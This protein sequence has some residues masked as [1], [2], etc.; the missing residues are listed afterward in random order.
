MLAHLESSSKLTHTHPHASLMQMQAMMS[1]MGNMD[2]G[3]MQQ[4]M[5]M[6]QN[7]SPADL[8]RAQQQMSGMDPS[9]L[10]SQAEQAQKM[11][12]AQQKYVLDVSLSVC[13]A[14]AAG[15]AAAT[16]A[17]TCS[18]ACEV[19]GL[20]RTRT[21]LTQLCAAG[22]LCAAGQQ[23]PQGRR[24]QAARTRY[25]Q[26]LLAVLPWAPSCFATA[27]STQQRV[28]AAHNAAYP[29]PV[30]HCADCA[31]SAVA[32]SGRYTEAAEK[33]ARARD[34]LEGM[35]NSQAVTLRRACVLNLSSCYLNN[36]KYRQC[37][38]CCQE[39]LAGEQLQQ[40]LWAQHTRL[41]QHQH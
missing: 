24:Q 25:R 18:P 33:Y 16:A 22:W 23:H 12:S 17:M 15:R 5:R 34:N 6:M 28:C 8:Q 3:L 7:M 4:Q 1:S 38:E 29:P 39:V 10:A 40:L 14:S 36:K 13:L 11:L 32:V 37:V 19:R 31:V 21:L 41:A 35:T 26:Q 2:P 20:L 27:C 30:P 9:T